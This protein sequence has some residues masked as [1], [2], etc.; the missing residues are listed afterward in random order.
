V[1]W[2]QGLIQV[3][4]LA[5]GTLLVHRSVFEQLPPPWWG[6]DY[7]RAEEN[8]YPSEDMYFC[9]LCR[10]AGIPL[11][12]DTTLTSPHLT[13]IVITEQHWRAWLDAHPDLIRQEA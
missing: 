2:P 7:G 11:W 6:Y 12:V 8:L 10:Q 4:A 5:H 9:Y 13:D 3:A 1:D